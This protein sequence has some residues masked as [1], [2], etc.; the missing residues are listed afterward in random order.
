MF[1]LLLG[2]YLIVVFL[3]AALLWASLIASKE[4]DQAKGYDTE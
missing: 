3:L 1:N 4:Y 2:I